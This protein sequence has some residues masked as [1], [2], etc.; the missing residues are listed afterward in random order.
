MQAFP[1]RNE[2]DHARALA[3]VEELWEA[4][5]GSANAVLVE[6]MSALIDAYESKH[7]FLPAADPLD[8]IADR[9][10]Q[11]GWSQRELARR[12]GWG[13]GRVS[14]VLNR[15][16]SLTLAMVRQMSRCLTIPAGLLVHGAVQSDGD[17]TVT[18]TGDVAA[19]LTQLAADAGVTPGEAL[20]GM[21]S[22][23]A[24]RATT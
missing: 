18:L 5:P 17:V 15:K 3:L 16:R 11:L 2:S 1:I 14:E 22:E 13:T 20:A 9:L 19:K 21:V 6:V 4:V 24:R 10:H 8:V 23:A 12:L 7:S